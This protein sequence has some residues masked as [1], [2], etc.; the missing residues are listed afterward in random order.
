MST[1]PGARTSPSMSTVRA[2]SS[3]RRRAGSRT[4]RPSVMP[5]SARR[6]GAPVPSTTSPPRNTRS[7]MLAHLG[8]DDG[9]VEERR[10]RAGEVGDRVSEHEVAKVLLRDPLVLNHLPRLVQHLVHL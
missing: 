4:M 8:L 7:S 9:A 3:D 6:R 5:T 10:I 2:A 1:K